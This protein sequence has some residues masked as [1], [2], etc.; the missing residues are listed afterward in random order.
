MSSYTPL[1]KT[2]RD[3]SPAVFGWM[4]F[5]GACN[6]EHVAVA[7]HLCLAT[8]GDFERVF[9]AIRPDARMILLD[10][11]AV[12]FLDSSGV[13]VIENAADELRRQDRQLVVLPG[14]ETIRRVFD[15]TGAS[16]RLEFVDTHAGLREL[17]AA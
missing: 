17:I 7:G 13:H 15:I 9:A 1:T 4:P 5:R 16:E 10:L 8:A 14:G 11:S 2:Q 12:F 3:T 6:I